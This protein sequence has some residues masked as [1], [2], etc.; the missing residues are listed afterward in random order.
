MH[1][2]TNSGELNRIL[3]A[4][5]RCLTLVTCL[6]HEHPLNGI[7]VDEKHQRLGIPNS[8]MATAM[9]SRAAEERTSSSKMYVFQLMDLLIYF[10]ACQML[11]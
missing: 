10:S 9:A 4:L 5:F 11:S 6:E 8:F 7:D 1:L 3:G 2:R